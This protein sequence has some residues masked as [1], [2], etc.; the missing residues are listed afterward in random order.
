MVGVEA[1][2]VKPRAVR[3]RRAKGGGRED[4]EVEDE[5]VV[6]G[7]GCV[8]GEVVGLERWGEPPGYG[9]AARHFSRRAKSEPR[10]LG[11]ATPRNAF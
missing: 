3:P 9:W 8:D 5:E 10:Q 4:V 2:P 6:V 1:A 7:S 11:N